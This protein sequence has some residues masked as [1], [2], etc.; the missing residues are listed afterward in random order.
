KNVKISRILNLI[1]FPENFP[2]QTAESTTAL[3]LF[4]AIALEKKSKS[5]RGAAA[6][7]S[8]AE[9]NEAAKSWKS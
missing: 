8:T 4:N 3:V 7:H 5:N 2:A 9:Q 6:E 1:L